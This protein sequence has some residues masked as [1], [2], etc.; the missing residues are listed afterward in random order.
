MYILLA[1]PFVLTFLMMWD[2]VREKNKE[3]AARQDV[4]SESGKID[5]FGANKAN[6]DKRID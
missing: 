6:D 1:V 3:I 4:F 5:W 2:I